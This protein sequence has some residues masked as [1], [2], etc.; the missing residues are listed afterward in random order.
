MKGVLIPDLELKVMIFNNETFRDHY[1][2]IPYLDEKEICYEAYPHALFL[3]IPRSTRALEYLKSLEG[4]QVVLGF[5]RMNRKLESEVVG[6]L[7]RTRSPLMPCM[8]GTE[9]P[10]NE[11][12]M[13]ARYSEVRIE[14][15][16]EIV[17]VSP[18]V[19]V[20]GRITDFEN[21][22]KSNAYVILTR[23][24]GFPKGR[25][26]TKT[27]ER[28]FYEMYVPEATYH[29]AFV[30]DGRYGRDA[31]EFYGWNVQIKPP[32]HELNA[33]FDKIE[34]YRLTAAETPE[35]TLIIEFL[36]MDIACTIEN[37]KR[38]YEFK[39]KISSE[40]ICNERLY[41]KLNIE[42]IEVSLS[43]ERLEI[44]TLCR[45]YYLPKDLGIEC[46]RP[47]YVLEA[48]IPSHI[49]PGKYDLRVIVHLD[50][51]QEWGESMLSGLHI[52]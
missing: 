27:N 14:N 7:T 20:H 51:T 12:L 16:R 46:P 35:R 11:K 8:V 34:L 18:Q 33:R 9:I 37:L 29:H 21:K 6:E 32:D 52:W 45:R 22:P 24:Y 17:E 2:V 26:I 3:A 5:F 44:R 4:K 48:K 42:D 50:E 36:P 13:R 41:P 1:G 43:D 10:L 39:G 31:L 40:D 25:A 38:I 30:C 19:R 49:P 23:P 28:G 47:I 15:I